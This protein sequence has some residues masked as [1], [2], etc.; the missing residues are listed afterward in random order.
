LLTAESHIAIEKPGNFSSRALRHI[1]ILR[2]VAL[3]IIPMVV[4]MVRS[5]SLRTVPINC[6]VLLERFPSSSEAL[7]AD[8]FRARSFQSRAC[9]SFQCGGSLEQGKQERRIL[10]ARDSTAPA[11]VPVLLG[12]GG[13]SQ[14]IS[15][16]Q[17][18]KV[19]AHSSAC[20]GPSL[21]SGKS[22]SFDIR[23]STARVSG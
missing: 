19:F 14:S 21:R 18:P 6:I 20:A 3:G 1:D 12:H 10:A 5:A 16:L 7:A 8:V 23:K 17:A 11:F 13:S 15:Q 2:T 9:T 22:A 4:S